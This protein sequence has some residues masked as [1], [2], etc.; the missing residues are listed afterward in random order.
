ML[1][2]AVKWKFKEPSLHVLGDELNENFG[3]QGAAG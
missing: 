1:D 3:S 2:I